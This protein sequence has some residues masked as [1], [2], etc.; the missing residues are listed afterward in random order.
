MFFLPGWI[1]HR[2]TASDRLN[3]VLK[4]T[5]SLVLAGFAY[6]VFV[7][8]THLSIPCV[9]HSLTGYL[10]PGCGIT[11]LVMSVLH[12]DL[13]GAR[14]ANMFIWHLFPLAAGYGAY[15][16]FK[17]VRNDDTG[18]SLP[19]LVLLS[20]VLIMTLAWGVYRNIC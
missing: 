19:E 11:R 3:I 1:M 10:C 18:F 13:E 2:P 16:L 12:G 17:Y 8:I 7:E 14:K 4:S 5:V 6:A 15:R 9:F 20:V